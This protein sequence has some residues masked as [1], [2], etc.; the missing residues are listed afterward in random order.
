MATSDLHQFI[1]MGT[2]FLGILVLLVRK[3]QLRESPWN[4]RS[5]VIPLWTFAPESK[6]FLENTG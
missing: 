2:K 3:F 4:F 6:K 5:L 1:S